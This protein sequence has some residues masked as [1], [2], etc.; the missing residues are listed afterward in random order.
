MLG[1][2]PGTPPLQGSSRVLLTQLLDLPKG[3]S[4]SV[5]LWA[6]KN[7]PPEITHCSKLFSNSSHHFLNQKPIHTEEVYG[8]NSLWNLDLLTSSSKKDSDDGNNSKISIWLIISWKPSLCSLNTLL[9]PQNN[10]LCLLWEN[11]IQY[12]E[13]IL[14]YHNCM[15]RGGKNP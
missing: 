5:P 6:F 14:V 10:P 12:L 7:L 13:E 11:F 1:T 4:C 2:Y 3:C 9:E 8:D 15:Q